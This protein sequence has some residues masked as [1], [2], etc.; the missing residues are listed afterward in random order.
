MELE[1]LEGVNWNG[2]GTWERQTHKQ[3]QVQER[4]L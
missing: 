2:Q 3:V 4:A 1:N